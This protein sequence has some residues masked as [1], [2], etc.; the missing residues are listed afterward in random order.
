MQLRAKYNTSV[1]NIEI[2]FKLKISFQFNVYY[3][4]YISAPTG[5]QECDLL[6]DP[7]HVSQLPFA[8][9]VNIQEFEK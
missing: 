5:G 4:G 1:F 6:G 2:L 8:C 7:N 3:Q 9:S